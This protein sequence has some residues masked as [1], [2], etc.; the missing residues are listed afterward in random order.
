[1]RNKQYWFCKI[2][3]PELVVEAEEELIEIPSVILGAYK[4]SL[5]ESGDR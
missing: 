3:L 1:M 2:S 5:L 4:E